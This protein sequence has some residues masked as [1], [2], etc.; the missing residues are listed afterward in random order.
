MDDAKRDRSIAA[1]GRAVHGH[2]FVADPAAVT[3][4]AVMRRPSWGLPA[5][6]GPMRKILQKILS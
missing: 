1:P 6:F 2:D 5:P 4:E 3:P